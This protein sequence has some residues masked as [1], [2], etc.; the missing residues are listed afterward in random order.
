[1]VKLLFLDM[2]G[3]GANSMTDINA[4]WRKMK[5]KGFSVK[6]IQ[7]TYDKKFCDGLEAIFPRKARLVSK[8]I[9][10]T[11]AKIVWSTTWRLCEPYKS[12]I[13]SARQML[14]KHS[15][16]GNALIGYT[17]DFG[18]G[19]FRCQEITAFLEYHYPDLSS[20]RC[21]VL[22]DWDEAGYDLPDNCRF[23]SNG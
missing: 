23:F 15:M 21:A 1:M 19:A 4:Y 10:E 12:D 9:A 3:A 16:P 8:I 7:R 11:D 6:A 20:C 13:S 18:P 22:D 17:P 14:L 5:K 2:D